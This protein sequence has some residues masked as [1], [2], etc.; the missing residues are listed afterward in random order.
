MRGSEKRSPA[1]RFAPRWAL[2]SFLTRRRFARRRY[3]LLLAD[4]LKAL[5][6]TEPDYNDLEKALE[7]VGASAK[8]NN[9]VRYL[10]F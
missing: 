3:K 8:H 5:P 2:S 6:P 7:L 10:R 4:L 9:E 1:R